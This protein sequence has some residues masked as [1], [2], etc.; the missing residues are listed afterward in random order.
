MQTKDPARQLRSLRRCHLP[1]ER[2]PLRG[3]RLSRLYTPELSETIERDPN[4]CDGARRCARLLSGYVYRRDR[5]SR[6]SEITVTYLAK[7]LDRS[8]RTVQRY[9]RQLERSGYIQ[10]EVIASRRSR[11]CVGLIVTLRTRLLPSHHAENWPDQLRKSGV[12]RLSQNHSYRIKQSVIP[13]EVWALRCMDG[14][15]RA[16]MRSLPPLPL[17]PG[18]TPSLL[19]I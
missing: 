4:L 12:T 16:L 10:T 13:V 6:R 15:F 9:L 3:T 17:F 5:Q 14:V 2:Q 7:A 18:E 8:R 19:Q 1:A 11:L